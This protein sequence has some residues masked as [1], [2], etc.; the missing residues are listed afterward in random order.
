MT[1]EN[2]ELVDKLNIMHT[3]R[4]V[5]ANN[6]GG[7]VKDRDNFCAVFYNTKIYRLSKN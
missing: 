7:V 2:D 1:F 4:E 6:V 3:N 5:G